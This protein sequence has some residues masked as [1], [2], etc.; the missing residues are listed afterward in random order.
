MRVLVSGGKGLVGRFI[1]NG[2][3]MAGHEVIVGARAPTQPDE[4]AL[5]LDRERDQREAFSGIDAFVHAA[6][7]HLPGRYRGGEGDDRDGF[8][9]RNLDGSARLFEEARSAGVARVLFLSTRAVY[10]VQ[11]HGAPLD[12]TTEPRADTLYG[13]VKLAAEAALL[14]LGSPTFRPTVLRITGVYG[15]PPAVNKWTPLVEAWLAG[16][17]IAP[18]AGTEVHG[19][20][21]GAAVRLVL[22][23]PAEQVA[24]QVLNVSDILVDTRDVLEVAREATGADRPLPAVADA[25]GINVMTTDRLRLLGWRPGGLDLFR[26]DVAALA[27]EILALEKQ[28]SS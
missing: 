21:V 8:R 6:F 10:G 27:T 18:R 19:R 13:E 4:R 24:G 14:R 17:P 5:H 25:S 26:R 23:S 28:G 12:E 15:G 3:V 2:L 9:R 20:D 16:E 7:D 1:V 22:E 11:P